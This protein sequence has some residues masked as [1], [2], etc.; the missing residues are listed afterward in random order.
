MNKKRKLITLLTLGII[1]PTNVFALQ[2][3]ETIYSTLDFYGTE[4]TKTISNHLSFVGTE[5]IEDETEL[6]DILNISGKETFHLNG[7]KLLWDNEQK[8]I[9]YEGQ[10]EKNLPIKTTIKY[11]LNEEEKQVEELLGKEG[12]IKIVLNFEN[13]EKQNV[14]VNGKT[15]ELYT[16]FVTTIGTILKNAKNVSVNNGK[17]VNTGS[18]TILLGL[19]SPGL[20][21]SLK[22]EEL[23]NLNQITIEYDTTSFELQNLYIVS[24]PKLLEEKDLEIFNKLD[25][26]YNNVSTLQTSMNTLEEKM[27]ELEKGTKELQKGGEELTNSLSALQTGI[28]KLKNGSV[29]L[30]QGLTEIQ[31]SLKNAKKE[32]QTNNQNLEQ[33]KTLKNQNT[34]TI[35]AL[36]KQTGMTEENLKK[37]YATYKLQ[38][39][40][41]KDASM[42]ALKNAYELVTLLK[43]NNV[44][45]E[46]T[47]KTTQELTSKLGTMLNTLETAITKA[48]TGAKELSTGLK[49]VDTGIK[50]I[51]TGSKTLSTGINNLQ[52]GADALAKG[53]ST[54]NKDGIKKLTNYANTLKSFTNRTEAL[55]SLSNNY[56]GFT[57]NNAK[58]TTFITK[59]ESSKINYNR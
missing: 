44:A 23:K 3:S 52:K 20:Y 33:I 56:N 47:I 9:F 26:L 31:N 16:P 22:L 6:L 55:L 54:L 32:M 41:G 46:S 13:L 28:E 35:N 25:N 2:K 7:E 5:P 27:K 48:T 29:S 58:E 40:T 53:T 15:E 43:T 59:V 36:V 19:A 24:T 42:L 8:D 4:K 12:K 45:L 34:K 21:E 10:T 14:K 30:E 57:S 39:Y 37:A 1:L 38:N 50:K 49:T 18:K 11:Y 17:I 51:Y